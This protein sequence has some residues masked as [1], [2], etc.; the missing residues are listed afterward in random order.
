MF[1]VTDTEAYAV[2][3]QY[4]SYCHNSR[5][6]AMRKLFVAFPVHATGVVLDEFLRELELVVPKLVELGFRIRCVAVHD[7]DPSPVTENTLCASPLALH[8]IPHLKRWGHYESLLD[9]LRYITPRCDAG[10]DALLWLS[11]KASG[12]LHQLPF[13]IEP[14][15]NG[16]VDC[17]F[18]QMV[19]RENVMREYAGIIRKGVG[20]LP[21]DPSLGIGG[22]WFP[23]AT[24]YVAVSGK[25][26]RTFE[27]SILLGK[28]RSY[29]FERTHEE[30][31]WGEDLALIG[32]VRYY[33][34][35]VVGGV[36]YEDGAR[37]SES[38]TAETPVE[39]YIE[40][41]AHVKRFGEFFTTPRNAN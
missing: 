3:R 14:V 29:F 13:V 41:H 33:G 30:A 10:T 37:D 32:A 5:E 23:S 6:T 31:Q 16:V 39:R 7:A 35:R 26:I 34:G 12:N 40:L 18:E 24:T 27:A 9:A 4:I 15:L 8:V 38:P 22:E 11:L 2:F 1:D 20:V 21:L 36:T 28:Y 17:A 19:N 25:F